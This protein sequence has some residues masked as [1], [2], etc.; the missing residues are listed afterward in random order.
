MAKATCLSHTFS[1]LF[2]ISYTNA[3]AMV[4]HP[5]SSHLLSLF[6]NANQLYLCTS[7]GSSSRQQS[8][9]VTIYQCQSAIPMHKQ[10]FIIQAAVTYCHYL[11]MPISYTYAQAMVRHPGSSH[12]LS[13]FIN[14]NSNP[15][16][17]GI[18]LIS[19]DRPV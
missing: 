13:L 11:S 14:A 18:W 9:I 17:Y 4:C 7:N 1:Q 8:L 6:I 15:F 12:L 16:L 2:S 5:G 10:W 3:Q 19:H